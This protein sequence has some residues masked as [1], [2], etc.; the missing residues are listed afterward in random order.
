MKTTN[1]FRFIHLFGFLLLIGLLLPQSGIAQK[2]IYES[3]I[4]V[5][6][7]N[8]MN[9][10]LFKSMNGK[11]YYL[12]PARSIRLG[13]KEDKETP[14]F[15][16]LKFTTEERESQG[17]MQGAL[18]HFLLEWGLTP[19]ELAELT[20]KLKEKA[21]RSFTERLTSTGPVVA[22]P[23]DLKS[24]T[25][26][27]FRIVSATVQDKKLTSSLITS[28]SAPI[29]P[30]GK[31]AV[32]ARL[33]KYGAQLLDATFKTTSSITDLSV[34]LDYDYTV[35]VEAVNAKI[36]YDLEISHRQGDDMAYDFIRKE[37]DNEPSQVYETAIAHYEGLKKKYTDDTGCGVDGMREVLLGLQAVDRAMSYEK[38]QHE[39]GFSEA[40]MRRVYDH[41]ES[42][43]RIK[44]DYIETGEVDDDRLDVLRDAFFNYFLKS[45]TEPVYPESNILT[46]LQRDDVE[47]ADEMIKNAHQGG[48]KFK[49]CTQMESSRSL[50]RTIKF[51]KIIMP[52]TRRHQMVSNLASTYDQVKHNPS[53]VGAINLNDKF[54]QHR[55]INLILDVEAMDIF[56]EEINYVTV[57]VR[58][59]RNQGNDFSDAVTIS[60][61]AMAERGR[62]ATLTY[63][64]GED[65]NP[66]VYEYKA[67]WS[68]RGGNLYPRN[69]GW[70]RGDWQAVT[71]APPIKPRTIEFEADL[72]D[73]RENGIRRA[74]LQLRYQKYGREFETIIPITV[75]RNEPL[76]EQTIYVDRDRTGYAYRIILTHE[77]HGKMATDW[78]AKITDDY[79]FATLPE[80]WDDD[81]F[82]NKLI[83]AARE[84]APKSDQNAE[85]TSSAERI[86][87]KVLKAAEIIFEK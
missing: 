87:D 5:V 37:L 62:L 65:T 30:G 64:R 46:D 11:Y 49:S 13:K 83:Q 25:G 15:L 71:L 20:A 3:K 43:E 40:M 77:E 31:A 14:E 59:R 60:P 45:F 10:T 35:L 85:I 79:V 50:K 4:E 74:S 17:G 8:G 32:A 48:Y 33:D 67:Q 69:P 38:G 76:A 22:G 57:N 66:D 7:D 73:L 26:E 6:L 70:Q 61:T 12:P 27:S 80:H 44:V 39:W 86:L 18:L 42:E 72:E 55:D 41:F 36:E 54:Y 81:R 1:C 47:I 34:V 52:V 56:E 53:C 82:I 28:G 24:T 2:L 16:F 63:A 19:A 51:D 75:S 84:F 21:R 78:Q 23:V 68:L 9:I 58:K 29:M